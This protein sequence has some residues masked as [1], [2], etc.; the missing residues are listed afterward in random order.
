MQRPKKKVWELLRLPQGQNRHGIVKTALR[1]LQ[2]QDVYK[3][4][5]MEDFANGRLGALEYKSAAGSLEDLKALW[6]RYNDK[7]FDECVDILH[8]FPVSY[9]HLDVYKRQASPW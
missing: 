7:P 8:I 5:V 9:T 2:K 1:F 4:Q 3:R 6:D